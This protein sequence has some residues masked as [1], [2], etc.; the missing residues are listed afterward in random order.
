MT[1]KNSPAVWIAASLTLLLLAL[2]QAAGASPGLAA[3]PPSEAL[4]TAHYDLLSRQL[5]RRVAAAA[6]ADSAALQ[7][8]LIAV[9]RKG[10]VF[11]GHAYLESVPEDEAKSKLERAKQEL[12]QLSRSERERIPPLCDGMASKLR[13]EA[14]GWQRLIVDRFADRRAK[15]LVKAEAEE[16]Q[17]HTA[18]PA[19][20][21]ASASTS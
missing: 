7:A 11:V 13:Q 1:L 14:A 4:C 10:S 16:L 15:R 2:T 18:P 3:A 17:R 21:K 6:E 5:A 9:L 19:G 8:E 12:S 20:K